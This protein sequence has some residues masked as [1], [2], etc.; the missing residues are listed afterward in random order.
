MRAFAVIAVF[1]LAL[2]GCTTTGKFVVPAGAQL[3]VYERPVT[4]DSNGMVTTRPFFWTAIGTPP[5]AG[6][7]YRVLKDGRVLKEGRLRAVFRPV[8][9]FWPPGALIYWPVGMN[10]NITYD[11][12]RDTQE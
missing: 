4:P 8:S 5:G 10:P 3:E 2:G 1:G 11:L 7:K 9:I 6:I 12:V